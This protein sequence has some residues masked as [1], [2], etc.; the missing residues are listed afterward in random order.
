M[1]KELFKEVWLMVL[2]VLIIIIFLGVRITKVA[3]TVQEKGL[4]TITE[5]IWH[6]EKK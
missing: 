4:K 5:E 6:G 2:I 3:K 1:F